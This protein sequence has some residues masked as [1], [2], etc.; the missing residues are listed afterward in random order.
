L[1]RLL[2]KDY[3]FAEFEDVEN[4][5]NLIERL[6]KYK[7]VKGNAVWSATNVNNCLTALSVFYKQMIK[8]KVHGITYNPFTDRQIAESRDPRLP[9]T[10]EELL[11]FWKLV[12]AL[13]YKKSSDFW[14]I[15]ILLYTG[16]R[17]GE[18]CQLRVADIEQDGSVLFFRFKD[19]PET[20]QKLKQA[21]AKRAKY[22]VVVERFTPVHK[23]LIQLG[24]IK[25]MTEMKRAGKI[26]LFPNEKPDDDGRWGQLTTKRIKTLLQRALGKET[27]KSSHSFRRTFINQFKQNRLV[28]DFP[29]NQMFKA[30]VGHDLIKGKDEDITW[31]LYADKY[32]PKAMNKL[33]QR[34]DYNLPE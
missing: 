12:K 29:E 13:P 4:V 5:H 14:I 1:N 24:F 15:L 18:V 22:N 10:R 3:N 6:K 9:L 33:L 11:L 16:C 19:D 7:S 32:E 28:K 34:L 2:G 17:I 25:Y 26:Q 30:M 31:D 27:D 21:R 8:D 20:D 23:E